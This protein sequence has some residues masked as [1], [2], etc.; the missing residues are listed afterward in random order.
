[1]AETGKHTA[2]GKKNKKEKENQKSD[3]RLFYLLTETR[4]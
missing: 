4:M 1:M 3:W 2:G